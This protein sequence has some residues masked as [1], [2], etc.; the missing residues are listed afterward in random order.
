MLSNLQIGT[1][2]MF[3][4]GLFSVLLMSVGALGLRN[5]ALIQQGLE[6]VYKDRVVPLRDIKLISDMYAVNIVDTAHKVRGGSLSWAQGRQRVEEAQRGIAQTWQSYLTTYLVEQE[7]RLV[8]QLTPRM[9]GADVAVERLR[10]ILHREDAGQLAEFTTRELY[11]SI[12]P[13]TGLLD[14]LGTLQLQV[15]KQEYEKAAGRY[16]WTRDSTVLLIAAGVLLGV[17]LGF[18][19]VRG[20]IQPLAEA[21]SFTERISRGDLTARV[22]STR[23]DEAGLL[24]NAMSD[25][26]ERLSRMIEEVLEGARSLSSAS[27]QVSA[28]A[29]SLAQGTSEQA[30]SV[31]ETASTLEQMSATLT[32]S[33][34]SSTRVAHM[35][36]TSVREAEEG[37]TAVRATVEAMET[38]TRQIAVIDEIAY[39]T[40]LL[41]LNAAIE[42]ARAGEH[43]RGFAVVATEVRKLAERSQ[44]AAREIN[45]LATSSVALAERSGKALQSLVPSIQRTHELIQELAASS[46]EQRRSMGLINSAVHQVNDVTQRNASSSEE[47]ASTAEEL[48]S[49]AEAFTQVMSVF[50]VARTRGQQPQ[51]PALHQGALARHPV[52]PPRAP[53]PALAPI[54]ERKGHTTRPSQDKHFRPFT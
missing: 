9:R 21:V 52:V 44:T 19:I 39:R 6:T 34:E 23:R 48:A 45:A 36:E 46:G 24:L 14:E 30:A 7:V 15:A 10:D 51:Q 1:R 4:V 25:M 18:F 31:E 12:D 28:T 13:V 42:S 29:Q 35:A 17:L 22:Q 26:S 2:L 47:L 20:I 32:R 5:M 53:Q 11:V 41:A 27:E 54:G 16:T 33:A 40:N 43:G 50:Q 37:G 8:E 49:Q 3:L 38:I